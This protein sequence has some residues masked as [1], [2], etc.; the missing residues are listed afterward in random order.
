MTGTHAP[1]GRSD[2]AVKWQDRDM[3]RGPQRT[4][5]VGCGKIGTRLGRRLV[6]RGG[7]VVAV[8]RDT[9]TL[10]SGFDARAIDL[11]EPVGDVLPETDAVV[12]TLTP[13]KPGPTAE[14]SGY[15]RALRNLSAALPSVPRRVIFV[16]STGVF[17][18]KPEGGELTEADPPC[19]ETERGRLLLAGESAAVELFGAHLVR[20][21]GIYGPGRGFLIRKVLSGEPVSYRKHTNRIHETDLVTLL[22]AAVTSPAAPPRLVHAADLAPAP[23]GEVV[24]FIADRL[25]VARPPRLD[26]DPGGG[27]ILRAENLAPL[28]G[29][30][31]YPT[32]VEG[33]SEIVAGWSS[34][35]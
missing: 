25:G 9:T 18:G 28:M 3:T 21:A 15:L 34:G 20:P 23:L 30:L 24:G 11:R 26:P 12:I 10:P 22:E 7:E 32:Y 8:R 19:P 29:A 1:A 14:T 33:Y 27:A 4:L 6:E 13:G 2:P 5:L 35:R 17:E 16:S 31:Q